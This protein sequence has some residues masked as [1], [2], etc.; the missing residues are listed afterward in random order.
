MHTSQRHVN[1][2]Q[3]RHVWLEG[4]QPHYSLPSS[5]LAALSARLAQVEATLTAINAP[6]F[7]LFGDAHLSLQGDARLHFGP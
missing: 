2:T 4:P 3:R 1:I 6:V 7:R 5:A